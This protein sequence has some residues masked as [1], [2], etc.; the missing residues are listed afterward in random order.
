MFEDQP[1]LFFIQRD[2]LLT[3]LHH[4]LTRVSEWI[5]VEFGEMFRALSL[6]GTNLQ[7]LLKQ[8]LLG[9]RSQGGSDGWGW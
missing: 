9:W 4:V 8:I 5:Q 1:H 6:V 7:A 2:Y 3:P